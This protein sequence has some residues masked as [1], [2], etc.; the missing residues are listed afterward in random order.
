MDEQTDM[1]RA[2]YTATIEMYK[3]EFG[4]DPPSGIWDMAKFN[5]DAG[6]DD[7]TK[8]KPKNS[9]DIKGLR[10]CSYTDTPPLYTYFENSTNNEQD[11][12][13]EFEE[14]HTSGAADGDW[15]DNPDSSSDSSGDGGGGCSGGCGGGD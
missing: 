7:P 6:D 8:P 15:S 10:S 13:P 2:Q 1:F 11:A 9:T 5:Q 14:G 3:K 12:F 4:V